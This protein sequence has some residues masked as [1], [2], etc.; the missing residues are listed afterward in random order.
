M[1]YLDEV[2]MSLVFYYF[3]ARQRFTNIFGEMAEWLNVA[4]SKTVVQRK[5]DPGFESQSLRHC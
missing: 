2:G 5:L 1:K 4:V 3:Y